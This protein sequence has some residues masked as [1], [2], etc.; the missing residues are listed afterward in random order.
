MK[1]VIHVLAAVFVLAL[2][3]CAEPAVREY[4][5]TDYTKGEPAKEP[6]PAVRGKDKSKAPV[7]AR[8]PGQGKS[9]SGKAAPP[10][11]GTAVIALLDQAK[12]EAATGDGD[13]AAAT[14]ERAIA[15]EPQNPWLWHRLAV[16]RLQQSRWQQAIE[17]A[18]KSNTLAGNHARLLGGNWKVIAGARE[19][20]GDSDGATEATATSDRFFNADQ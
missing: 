7:S 6:I 3:G 18:T 11:A 5:P 12:Q 16:L 10:S 2:A 13:A 17:I 1:S 9:A 20:L 15:I 14:L 19:G 8:T 4:G